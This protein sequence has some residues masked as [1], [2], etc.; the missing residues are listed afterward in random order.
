[1]ALRWSNA[2][3]FC[4]VPGPSSVLT[5]GLT[6][7]SLHPNPN[8]EWI[9]PYTGWNVS[10]TFCIRREPETSLHHVS[11]VSNVRNV[12]NVSSQ[13]TCLAGAAN[14]LSLLLLLSSK[15]VCQPSHKTWLEEA[16]CWTADAQNL[17]F[18]VRGEV[19][20]LVRWW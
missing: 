7:C 10:L 11:N 20:V 1:M 16:G 18:E 13:I 15:C 2:E 19:E 14:F 3:T 12:S 17:G 9:V 4:Q 8:I 5:L 6:H